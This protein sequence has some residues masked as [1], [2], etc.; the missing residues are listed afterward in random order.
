MKERFSAQEWEL[1]KYMPYQIFLLVAAADGHI[2]DK[3]LAKFNAQLSELEML[4]S[5]LHRDLLTD[6][7]QEGGDKDVRELLDWEKAV[8][9][10]DI[11]KPLLKDKLSE[12]EY[13]DFI[14]SIF[15]NA[16]EVAQASG[17]GLIP[18]NAVSEKEAEVLTG[19][20]GLYEVD[21]SFLV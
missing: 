6:F 12:T 9:E 5:K 3:E 11:I 8:N 7:V 20:A 15:L 4:N 13:Q 16:L 10:T 21:V 18:H 19:F 1:L 14:T 17:D 2:D